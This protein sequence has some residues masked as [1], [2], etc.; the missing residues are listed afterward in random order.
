M[1]PSV[2][3]W[4]CLN[5]DAIK[6]IAMATMLLNHIANALLSP[7]SPWFEPLVN[8]GY[9]TAVTMCYFLVEGYGYTHDRKAYALRLL[10]FALIAQIP[11]QL[12]LGFFQLNMLF[13]LLACFGIVHVWVSWGADKGPQKV[14]AVLGLFFASLF[15]DWAILAP[16]FTLMFASWRY[17]DA[18][19]CGTRSVLARLFVGD[20][21]IFFFLNLPAEWTA[22]AMLQAAASSLGIL[23]AGAVILLFYNGKRAQHGRV[24]WKW[25]FYLFYPAHLAV[26]AAIKL[27]V[28][29]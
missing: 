11:Y 4:P 22:Q 26:L 24:F 12:A 19:A 3:I 29:Q 21:L 9:F 18:P 10:G 13:T 6:A 16:V 25:F 14:L 28:L 1:K 7:Q 17:G 8:I 27:L 20:A 15:M 2:G 23:A 5:R